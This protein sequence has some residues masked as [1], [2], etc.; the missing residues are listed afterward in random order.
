MLNL[1]SNYRAANRRDAALTTIAM[2]VMLSQIARAQDTPVQQK[3]SGRYAAVNGLRMYYEI[4]GE[5]RNGVRPL[6]LLH[7]GMSNIATDFGTLLPQL[8]KT[9]QVIAIEQQGHGHTAD[10]DRP[11]TY[12]QMGDDTAELLRQLGVTNADFFGYSV[13]GGIA[14]Q[15]AQRYPSLV[16]KVVFA[17]GAA[18]NPNGYYPEMQSIWKTLDGKDLISSPWQQA[19]ARIAPD[20]SAWPTLVSKVMTLDLTWTGWQPGAV[21]T[22]TAPALLIVGDA[23]IVQPEHVVQLFR[24]LGGGVPG[25]VHGLPRAQLAVLP[26]TTHVTLINRTDWL[27]SMVSA[28]L[29]APIPAPK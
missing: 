5:S 22:I 2:M 24:L 13:G 14:L 8:T 10:I 12:K 18:Y 15:I 9:R 29:D 1:F 26:G 21:S 20:P 23:D 16:H 7:G 19:Y 3:S 25:D 17:G 6:V 28:F 4:H 27:F 11:L